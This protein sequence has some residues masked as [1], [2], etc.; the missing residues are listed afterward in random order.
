MFRKCFGLDK[1][2]DTQGKRDSNIGDLQEIKANSIQNKSMDL[3]E[4]KPIDSGI[5]I[6]HLVENK[7]EPEIVQEYKSD[8]IVE[9]TPKALEKNSTEV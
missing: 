6:D 3:K 8:N 5:I 2:S 7:I 1:I 9:L 4:D